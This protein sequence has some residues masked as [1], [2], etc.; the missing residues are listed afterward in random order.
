MNVTQVAIRYARAL[1]DLALEQQQLE[2]VTADIRLLARIYKASKEIRLLLQ[3]PVVSSEKKEKILKDIFSTQVSPV[4]MKFM[5]LLA[6]KGRESVLPGITEAFIQQYND[7]RNI[8]PVQL[9]SS[10][11]LT[12]EIRK[13]I[14]ALMSQY[15]GSTIELTE[16]TDSALIGGFRL[17]WKDVQYDATLLHAIERLKRGE[18]NPNL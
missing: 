10:A 15:T 11:P 9:T 16:M 12:N 7:Y 1:F 13:Q 17:S 8:L 3:S 4:T 5:L 18:G 2:E 14:T 6:R